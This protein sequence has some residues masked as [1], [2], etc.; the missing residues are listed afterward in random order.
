M[1]SL[2][3]KSDFFGDLLSPFATLIPVFYVYKGYYAQEKNEILKMS[4]LFFTLSIFSWFV[5]EVLWS[6]STIVLKIDTAQFNIILYGYS[7]T[8]LFLLI[9]LI[10]SGYYELKKWNGIQVLIDTIV[11]TTCIIILAWV[12]FLNEDIKNAI[13]MKNDMIA[14]LSLATDFF[15]F[16]WLNIWFF[17]IR[18]GKL[19]LF[20]KITPAG[21][22]LYVVVDIIYYYQ[23]FYNSYDPNSLPDGGYIISF[24]LMAVGAV[25]RLKSTDNIHDTELKNSGGKGK[26]IFMLIA[27]LTLILFRGIMMEYLLLMLFVILLYFIFSYYTQ[28]NIY[29]DE[30][31]RKEKELVWELEKNVQ[32]RIRE[33]NILLNRDVVTELYSRRYFLEYLNDLFQNLM[34]NENIILFYIDLNKFKMIKTMYGNYIAEMTLKE[35]GRR[36][37]SYKYEGEGILASYGDDVFVLSIK[38]QFAYAEGMMIAEELMNLSSDIYHIEGNDIA[39]TV[40]IGFSILPI[41]ANDVVQLIKNADIAMSQARR[42]GYNKILPFDKDLGEM[43]FT[44]NKIEIMLKGANYNDEFM[45]HFQP[46]VAAETGKLIGFE[47]LIRWKTKDGNSIPPSEFIPIAEETGLIIPIGYWVM[48]KSIEQLVVWDQKSYC[49][50]KMSINVSAKQLV[51]K[52]FIKSLKDTLVK[53]NISAERLEIEITESI[54][55]DESIELTESLRKISE[56]GI[57]IA[58]DD[59]GTGY[60]SLFYLKKLPISRIKIAKPLVDKI[61]TDSYDYMIVK[62][63][64]SIAKVKD[65]IVIAEGV[66]TKEQLDCLKK[67]K[68]DEI[69]G[70]YF[71]RPLPA[72]EAFN[73]WLQLAKDTW[74][75]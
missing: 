11:I 51:D 3:I 33:I 71:S 40:N 72:E 12:L 43:I 54:Q 28:K 13:I 61:D 41:D 44:K 27:P 29:R 32:E 35:M 56:M 50:P 66:E 59:F 53:N 10:L 60:S 46:Q 7:L 30:L 62:S 21:V 24:L 58:I 52:K 70:Y 57:S 2:Y 4:G 23:Y 37:N 65:V 75:F 16:I 36:L 17:S 42:T 45:L 68:C 6:I 74:L 49:K 55:L 25:A 73:K 15:I 8:N 39:V 9:S 5:F 1:L 47:A 63:A 34:E 20:L 19:P 26:G 67:L 64:V 38:G 69:Q 14:M 31:L 48:K 18:K 22:L